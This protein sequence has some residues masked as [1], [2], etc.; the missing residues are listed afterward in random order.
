MFVY[1]ICRTK[2]ANDLTG[3]GARLYGGR[4]NRK[5]VPCLYTSSSIS[6]A[7]LEFSVNVTLDQLPRALSLVTIKI[8]DEVHELKIDDLPGNWNAVPAPASAKDF[9]SKM[10][11][12][13]KH[14]TIKLPSSIITREFNYIINPLHPHMKQC[15]IISVEDFVFDVRIKDQG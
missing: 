12:D 7:I 9:G 1:R 14:L 6:L 2:W 13:A 11:T 4:W 3:E 8:P 10:L 15:R 5:G